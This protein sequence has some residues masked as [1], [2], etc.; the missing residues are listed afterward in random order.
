MPK[1]ETIALLAMMLCAGPA[2]ALEPS[3][4]GAAS[5]S[6]CHGAAPEATV[7]PVLAGRPASEI[8]DAMRGFREGRLPATVMDRIAKGF[9]DAESEAIAAWLGAQAATR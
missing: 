3:P 2:V 7:G 9:S 5:C 4:P 8:V 1:V 6:G